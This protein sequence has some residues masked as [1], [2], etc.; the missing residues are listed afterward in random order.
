MN[1][2]QSIA[3]ELQLTDDPMAGV[4]YST[5][6]TVNLDMMIYKIEDK[7]LNRKSE[8]LHNEIWNNENN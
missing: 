8:K 6:Q 1:K 2:L 4:I 7:D 5:D 3:K